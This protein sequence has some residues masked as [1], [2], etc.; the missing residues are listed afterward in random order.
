[1]DTVRAGAALVPEVGEGAGWVEKELLEKLVPESKWK[2]PGHKGKVVQP[3]GSMCGA[4]RG[5]KSLLSGE[6]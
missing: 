6:K 5:Q 1:M 4:L 3:G 2:V